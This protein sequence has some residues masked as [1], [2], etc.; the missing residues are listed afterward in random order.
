[1]VRRHRLQLP[2]ELAL[3]LKTIAM[4]ENLWRELDPAFN[5]SAVAER[6]VHEAAAHLYSPATL[7]RPLGQVTANL[8][9]RAAQGSGALAPSAAASG[10]DESLAAIRRSLEQARHQLHAMAARVSMAVVAAA[11]ILG[12]PILA[13]VHPPPGWRLLAPAWFFAGNLIAAG[14]IVRL[15]IIGRRKHR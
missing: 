7:L 2:T 9:G 13:A 3:L 1:V 5:A 15:L 12:L 10:T 6:F 8:A 14:L 4:S 11:F